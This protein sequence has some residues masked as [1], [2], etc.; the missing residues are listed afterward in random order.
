M[1][2][3]TLSP[4]DIAEE[5]ASLDTYGRYRPTGYDAPGA[6]LTD[7]GDWYVLPVIRTRDSGTLGASNFRVATAALAAVDPAGAHHETHRFGHWACGWLEIMIVN[8]AAPG[9]VLATAATI[10]RKLDS[11]PILSEDDYSALESERAAET[12]A[13]MSIR[14]RIRTCARYKVSIFAARRDDVPDCPSGE[15]MGYLAGE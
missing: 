15:I 6:C 14:D 1:R 11:Y 8:P 5:L 7:R 2:T 9:A 13:G 12:W 3:L 10:A 4:A